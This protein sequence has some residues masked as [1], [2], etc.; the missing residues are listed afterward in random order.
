MRLILQHISSLKF[1]T[2]TKLFRK[3]VCFISKQ[4]RSK[5]LIIYMYSVSLLWGKDSEYRL[6]MFGFSSKEIFSTFPWTLRWPLRSKLFVFS[7]LKA[8]VALAGLYYNIFDFFFSFRDWVK[9]RLFCTWCSR[10]NKRNL[11]L[12]YFFCFENSFCELSL[13]TSFYNKHWNQNKT[14]ICH[15][16]LLV[17]IWNERATV[18]LRSSFLNL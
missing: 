13:P 12:E 15:A 6:G 16:L 3:W 8:A 18:Q 1:Y 14:Y 17:R 5:F 11:F 10:I 9:E 4:R 2:N 7:I